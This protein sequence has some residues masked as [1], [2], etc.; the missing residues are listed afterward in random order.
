MRYALH[1]RVVQGLLALEDRELRR[2][3]GI[4]EWIVSD[5]IGCASGALVD[6]DGLDVLAHK[7]GR[8][9]LFY[10]VEPG[11]RVIFTDLLSNP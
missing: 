5:P 8:L 1:D 2:L 7:V 6:D 11:G 9:V 4:I 3:Y 10:F